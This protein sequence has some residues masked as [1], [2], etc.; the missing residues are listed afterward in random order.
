MS[1]ESSIWHFGLMAERWAEFLHET[2]ELDFFR[3]AVQ[4][5][6]EPVLD[7][8]CGTGRLLLPLLAE[9]FDIDG[10]DVSAD[11]LDHCRRRAEQTGHSVE[12]YNQP[13]DQL[14]LPRRYRT[15]YICDSFGLSGSRDKDLQCL[16][17]CHEYL[18]PGGA[19]I[20]NIQAEYT[21]PDAWKMWM[22]ENSG[23]LPEPWPENVSP[24]VASD[25]TEHFAYFRLIDLDP[26][27]QNYTRAVRLEK[28]KNG[29]LVSRE[30]YTLRGRMYLMQEL[31][32]MLKVA[33][34]EQISVTGDY[35]DKPA[36]RA[37]EEIV[38][39]AVK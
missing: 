5:Y 8:A 11:M 10:C 17:L 38:F 15:I 1:E 33:G 12:L 2:P 21:T 20:V 14:D 19:L 4:E 9:G 23:S 34:F 30:E 27:N 39:T 32:L 31:Q 35:T 7:L 16:R 22:T 28:R 29:E 37:S 36:T 13:M 18:R 24:R 6:G 3:A 26:L 25:G